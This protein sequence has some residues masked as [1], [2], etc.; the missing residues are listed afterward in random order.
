MKMRFII[1][2]ILNGIIVVPSLMWFAGASLLSSV[3]AAFVLSVIAYFL[4]DQ[5]VLRFSNNLVA[6]IADAVLAY[7]YF[8]IVSAVMNWPLSRSEILSIVVLLGVVEFI[9][10]QYLIRHDEDHPKSDR[11][12]VVL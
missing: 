6:T 8:W 5:M 1:K 4:G 10:H 7:V 2:L 3:M 12:H 9:Y 11:S